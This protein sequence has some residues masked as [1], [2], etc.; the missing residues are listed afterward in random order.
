VVKEAVTKSLHFV[1]GLAQKEEESIEMQVGKLV[2]AIQYLQ[3]SVTEL[4]IQEESS[5]PQEVHD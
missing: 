4:D 2:E 5:T 1:S 3:V